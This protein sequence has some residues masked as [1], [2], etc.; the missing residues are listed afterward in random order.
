MTNLVPSHKI[1]LVS[2]YKYLGNEIKI[3]RDNQT[4][5]LLR[6]MSLGSIWKIET[7]FYIKYPG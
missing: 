7:H 4:Y 3:G 5:D 6:R 1:E 2:S